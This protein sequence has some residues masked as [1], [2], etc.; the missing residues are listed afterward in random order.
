[1]DPQMV[2]LPRLMGQRPWRCPGVDTGVRAGTTRT[3][4]SMNAAARL[5]EAGP[6]QRDDQTVSAEQCRTRD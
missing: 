2:G 3:C 1:V 4:L 5:R 6:H